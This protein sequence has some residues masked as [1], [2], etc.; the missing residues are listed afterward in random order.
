[1]RRIASNRQ[2]R[3]LLNEVN[4]EGFRYGTLNGVRLPY[5]SEQEETADSTEKQTKHMTPWQREEHRRI[6]SVQSYQRE[7]LTPISHSLDSM[8]NPDTQS[9]RQRPKR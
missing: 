8:D 3:E 5:H 9:L 4:D 2:L 7:R 1:M 6:R